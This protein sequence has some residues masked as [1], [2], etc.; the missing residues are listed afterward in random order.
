[1]LYWLLDGFMSICSALYER[2]IVGGSILI[3][4]IALVS[5]QWCAIFL[6]ANLFIVLF[7]RFGDYLFRGED[8]IEPVSVQPQEKEVNYDL[9]GD[10]MW[11]ELFADGLNQS[12][13][14]S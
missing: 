14:Q 11:D 9:D 2:P 12:V 8:P 6:A 10:A 1:M 5:I 4:P 3:A 13:G 7:N